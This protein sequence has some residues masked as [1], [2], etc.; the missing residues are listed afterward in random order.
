MSRSR[1]RFQSGI[2]SAAPPASGD[3]I[4]ERCRR[5]SRAQGLTRSRLGSSILEGGLVADR[6]G[7]GFCGDR[8]VGVLLGARRRRQCIK[9]AGAPA[10][11]PRRVTCPGSARSAAA[12]L[13][14]GPRNRSPGPRR[15]GRLARDPPPSMSRVSR[16]PGICAGSASRLSRSATGTPVDPSPRWSPRPGGAVGRLPV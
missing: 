5:P 13:K 1:R 10:P 7:G 3:Q 16:S 6:V 8:L 15:S 12:A 2:C 14:G 4:G 9:P 11:S